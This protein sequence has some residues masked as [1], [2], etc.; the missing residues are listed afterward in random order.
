MLS[1]DAVMT[2]QSRRPM[3]SFEGAGRVVRWREIMLHTEARRSR[4]GVWGRLALAASVSVAAVSLGLLPAHAATTT[5]PKV[6][7]VQPPELPAETL[8]TGAMPATAT[9]RVYVADVA[10]SHIADGRIR[11]FD[12]RN[13][14]LLG[15]FGSGYAANF[16]MSP[17]ADE[18][19]IA[20]TYM[21]RLSRGERSDVLEVHDTATLAF[22]YEVLLPP[23][24]AQT[25][26]YRGMV[27]A[28]SNGRWVM[29][30][31]A[32]PATSIT[33]VDL[34]QRKVANE[35]ATPGCWGIQASGSN[36]NR[37][38]TLCGDGKMA[39]ITLD[40][41][42][43]VADRQLSEKFFDADADAWFHSA[44]TVGDRN[45]YL[46][47][48]GV[49]N[50]LDLSGPVAKLVKSTPLV[51]GEAAKQGWRPG[52]Y[53]AFAVDPSARWAVVAMHPKGGEGSHKVPAKELWT[54]DL[55]SGKRVA[56]SPGLGSASLAF[57]RNGERLHALDGLTGGMN[58]WRWSST[59]RLS[60]PLNIKR[61]GEAALHL[62]PHD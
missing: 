42:G 9:E 33:V 49:L 24:R 25:L 18:L 32:T 11:V 34:Q 21:A 6:P 39:T 61:A 15:M 44:E 14:S 51:T 2:E 26:N 28:S 37:F 3:P 45:W 27:R 55:A 13:G 31:N 52:G 12:A 54:V 58:I 17:K 7:K 29:V 59:G 30:Q 4:R 41:A 57:S 36:G 19:Y 1:A 16:G 40:D 46:S 5:K 35:I 48:K 8:T 38:S 60:K 47:F 20:T 10:I 56:K 23:K 50:E 53:Q 62:E 22:K 43:Q